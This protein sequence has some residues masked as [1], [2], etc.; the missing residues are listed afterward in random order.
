MI[1]SNEFKKG[2]AIKLEKDIYTI[3]DFQHVKPGKGAAFVRSKIKSLTNGRVIDKTFRA[4]E[5]IEDIRVE[6][7]EMQYSYDEGDSL[8]FM[9]TETFDQLP[10]SK[11]IVENILDYIKEGD[12]VEISIYEEKPISIEPPIFVELEVTYSEPG[13]KGDTATNVQKQVEVETGAKINVPIFVNTGDVI[14]I[15]TRSGDYVERVKR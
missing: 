2:M 7:R 1:S 4:G 11:E 14:K 8:V 10:V 9:D 5:K 3:V 15:D 6:R 13:V 12:T